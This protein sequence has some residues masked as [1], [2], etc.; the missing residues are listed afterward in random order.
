MSDATLRQIVVSKD[1][2]EGANQNANLPLIEQLAPGELYLQFI[3]ESK[4]LTINVCKL[5]ILFDKGFYSKDKR[6]DIYCRKFNTLH[7]KPLK[8]SVFK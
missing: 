3:F 5:K 4:V 7:Q 1:A 6:M 2:T 8:K